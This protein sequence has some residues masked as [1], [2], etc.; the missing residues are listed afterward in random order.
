MP[1]RRASAQKSRSLYDFYRDLADQGEQKHYGQVGRQMLE[2]LPLMEILCA[3]LPVWGLTSLD[4][5]LLLAKDEW[6]SRPYV[7]VYALPQDGYG[8]EYE[9]PDHEAPWPNT[10]VHGRA[11]SK[12]E[13]ITMVRTAMVRSGGW[14][15]MLEN[16]SA[17]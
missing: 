16:P 2:L 13:A 12:E 14:P 7:R 15:G 4:S 1:L 8:I 17:P 11:R 3:D 9:M 10:T 5:L 6:H